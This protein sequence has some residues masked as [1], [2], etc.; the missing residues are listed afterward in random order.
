MNSMARHYKPAPSSAGAVSPSSARGSL[1]QRPAWQVTSPKSTR[2]KA[3]QDSMQAPQ[4][5]SGFDYEAEVRRLMAASTAPVQTY[6]AVDQSGPGVYDSRVAPRT[7]GPASPS[8]FRWVQPE[9]SETQP[10]KERPQRELSFQSRAR[11]Q[12]YRPVEPAA[13]P[14]IDTQS[15]DWRR[16]TAAERAAKILGRV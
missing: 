6:E 9:C 7:S 15:P 8:R 11:N 10:P 5:Q 14:A 3:K 4:A 12:M 13:K 1:S 16:M 2:G